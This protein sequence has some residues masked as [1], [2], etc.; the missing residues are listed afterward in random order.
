MPFLIPLAG[1]IV[2]AIT[3]AITA[4]AAAI[5]PII[6]AIAAAVASV[7]AVITS[8]LAPIVATVVN[9]VVWIGSTVWESIGWVADWLTNAVQSA[10][11]AI[12]AWIHSAYAT[13]HAVLDAIHFKL[14][15]EIHHIAYIVSPQYRDM[16]RKVYSAISSA[17]NALGLGPSFLLLALQNTRNLVLDVSSMFGKKYDLSQLDWMGTMNKWLTHFQTYAERY[18]SN[19]EAV[20]WDL[21]EL[22][23]RPN[24]D[25]KGAA[26]Q[27]WIQ[28]LDGT[29]KWIDKFVTDL[30]QIGVDTE[31]LISDLPEFVKT[32]IP[33]QIDT[34]WANMT[35]YLDQYLLPALSNLEGMI[36]SAQSDV[37]LAREHVSGLVDRLKNPGQYLKEIETLPEPERIDAISYV[38][39][40]ASQPTVRW[41]SIFNPYADTAARK[42][43]ASLATAVPTIPAPG[44]L[45]LE[46]VPAY[47]PSIGG[48]T[49]RSTW[50]VGDY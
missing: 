4:V 44:V 37:E 12:S 41:L 38:G 19:P 10:Y 22:I 49:P 18:R 1:V 46:P 16:M 47:I 48:A 24:L 26:Q 40:L 25:A 11:T 21:A 33:Q 28:S 45:R 30:K 15:L 17:S 2:S 13:I 8:V 3:A 14:I 6:T 36:N 42:I 27:V 43:A 35:P 7:S 39:D 31:K 20:F 32:H 9:A 50:F 23:E 5:A 29:V 34:F